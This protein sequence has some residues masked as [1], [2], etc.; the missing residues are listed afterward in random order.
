MTKAAI[1]IGASL[2][3]ALLAVRP[4]W[5]DPASLKAVG[6]IADRVDADWL[7]AMKARDAD[8]L[9]APYA[10]DALFVLSNGKVIVGHAA[11]A[12]LYRTRTAKLFKVIGGG[13]HR[14]GLSDGGKDL[15][16]EWGH[17]GLTTLDA[18][19]RTSSS[20]GPYLTV[21]KLEPTIAG[22]SSATLCSSLGQVAGSKIITRVVPGLACG[23][24]PGVALGSVSAATM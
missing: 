20:D 14:E 19:G 23:R 1:F 3:F 10:E 4:A 8:R 15:V 16:Y 17:G 12:A 2:T 21:W 18:A 13:I 24:P 22:A 7:S 9:A 6:A 5:A 11:I